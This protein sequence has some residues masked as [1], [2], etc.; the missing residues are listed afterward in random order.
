M[1]DVWF[2]CIYTDSEELLRESYT[3][4]RDKGKVDLGR[5]L[6][7]FSVCVLVLAIWMKQLLWGGIALALFGAGAYCLCIPW[8]NARNTMAN[9]Q[10]INKGTVP[11]ASIVI[12]DHAITHYYKSNTTSIPLQELRAVYFLKH[13]IVLIAEEAYATFERTGFTKGNPEEL[14]AFIQEKCPQ[15][16]LFHKA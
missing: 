7:F 8:I 14:E 1:E 11:S 4:V 5:A 2:E 15:V 16:Q 6:L 9:I 10:R 12:T 3:K 13:S